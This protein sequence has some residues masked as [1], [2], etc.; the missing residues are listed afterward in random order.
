MYQKKNSKKKLET[1]LLMNQSKFNSENVKTQRYFVRTEIFEEMEEQEEIV[2]KTLIN[3]LASC[4]YDVVNFEKSYDVK[5]SIIYTAS[6]E[7][8]ERG[9]K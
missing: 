1:A 8:V 5:G 9:N 2:L 7:V 4:L 6:I 3:Q